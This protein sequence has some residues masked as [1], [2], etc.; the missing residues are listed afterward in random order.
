MK[1]SFVLLVAL[2]AAV[3]GFQY[4]K[5]WEAWKKEHGRVYESDE[6]EHRRHTIWESNM[7]FVKEHNA[8]AHEIGFTVRINEFSDLVS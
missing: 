8:R 2:A 7:K 6:I 3:S 5:E 1:C 4:T